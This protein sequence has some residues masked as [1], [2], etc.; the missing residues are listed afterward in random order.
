MNSLRASGGGFLR[1]MVQSTLSDALC[2]FGGAGDC[3]PSCSQVKSCW[4]SFL[5][6]TNYCTRSRGLAT[7]P[8]KPAPAERASEL[9][10]KM[11]SSPNVITKTGAVVLSTGLLAT[12]ISQELY[13]VN[14]ETIVAAGFFILVG[15]LTKV[16]SAATYIVNVC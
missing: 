11:P 16:S 9:I 8:E 10:N 2:S 14:E 3:S 4:S 13:V 12:A 15:Y 6:L 5:K 7:S 1:E